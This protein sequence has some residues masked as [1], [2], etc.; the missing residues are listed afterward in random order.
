MLTKCS[1]SLYL[2]LSLFIAFRLKPSEACCQVTTSWL[3]ILESPELDMLDGRNPGMVTR[4]LMV[5]K[6]SE[7]PARLKCKSPKP[8]VQVHDTVSGI[9]C[10]CIR[11]FVRVRDK[12]GK[13]YL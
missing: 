6:C 10:A 5:V 11:T 1:L 13:R 7:G 3:Q 8:S 4:K 12:E 9:Q 2:Y